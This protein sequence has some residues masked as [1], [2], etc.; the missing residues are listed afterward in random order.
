MSWCVTRRNDARAAARRAGVDDGSR[1]RVRGE[2]NAGRR[3]GEP[4][5]LYVFIGVRPHPKGLRREGTTVH[6]DIDI[7]YI[8]AILGTSV[9]ARGC[10][11]GLAV[12]AAACVFNVPSGYMVFCDKQGVRAL[13]RFPAISQHQHSNVM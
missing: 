5:D 7:S 2:G 6:S 12:N 1:L 9:Q 13:I 4:G 11:A 8:D 3:G 10:A